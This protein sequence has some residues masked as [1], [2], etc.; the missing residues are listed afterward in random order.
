MEEFRGGNMTASSSLI[1][2]MDSGR[3]VGD[4][5][6][7][8]P[9]LPPSSLPHECQ[10]CGKLISCRRNLWK[11][12]ERVHLTNPA[13]RCS[14]CAKLFKNKYALK[15][16]Q[17]IYHGGLSEP[18]PSSPLPHPH[19]QSPANLLSRILRDTRPS[20]PP[21]VAGSLSRP[22]CSVVSV[23]PSGSV[24]GRPPRELAPVPHSPM[25][26]LPPYHRRLLEDDD[27]G[28]M[29]GNLESSRLPPP[30]ALQ[31]PTP[32]TSM[33]MSSTSSM[34]SRRGSDMHGSSSMLRPS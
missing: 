25:E 2:H 15:D 4:I 27:Q 12:M 21:S 13:V 14:I 1:D 30:P 33:H 8:S 16:H 18:L 5:R 23:S 22:S 7:G 20:C 34:S 26:G 32:A 28:A 10:V 31:P 9:P 24:D 17:R 29:Y 6:S 19:H 3:C 11:H